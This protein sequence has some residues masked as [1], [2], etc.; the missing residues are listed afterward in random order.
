MLS[1]ESFRKIYFDHNPGLKGNDV[2]LKNMDIAYGLYVEDR[3][4]YL[5]PSYYSGEHGYLLNIYHDK[6]RMEEDRE[7]KLH[8]LE[9]V[10][11]VI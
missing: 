9:E 10:I 7:E 1:Y 5:S 4:L 8:M 11:D 2:D 3:E 6:I